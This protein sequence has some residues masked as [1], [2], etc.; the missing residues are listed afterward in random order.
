[1]SREMSLKKI[2]EIKN[3]KNQDA[4]IF[5]DILKKSLK[6]IS[7]WNTESEFQKKK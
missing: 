5:K 7:F 3:V 2:R 4:E 1:M 6:N